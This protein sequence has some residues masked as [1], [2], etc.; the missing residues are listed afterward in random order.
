MG[1]KKEPPG[2]ILR[3]LIY[4]RI[5]YEFAE[6]LRVKKYV[7]IA[8]YAVENNASISRDGLNLPSNRAAITAVIVNVTRLF[9]SINFAN[10]SFILSP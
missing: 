8:P 10:F 5:H 9:T 1:I 3:A 4:R 7:I 6:S 2:I